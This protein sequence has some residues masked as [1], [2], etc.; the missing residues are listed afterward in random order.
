MEEIDYTINAVKEVVEYL[1]Q[2]SPVWDEL[3]KGER[4]YVI[5]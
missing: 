1:R 4:E 3:E 2:I 5:Q